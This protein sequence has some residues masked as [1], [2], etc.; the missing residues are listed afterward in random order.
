VNV[1]SMMVMLALVP[2]LVP[3]ERLRSVRTTKMPMRPCVSMSVDVM[4][5]SV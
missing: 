4:S 3:L 5:V 2:V 1:L